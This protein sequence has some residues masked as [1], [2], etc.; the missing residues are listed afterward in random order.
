[1]LEPLG[2][3]LARAPLLPVDAYPTGASHDRV[4]ESLLPTEPLVRA[5]L[6]V[7]TT[8]LYSAL[9]RP[10]QSAAESDR[11]R[12]KLLRYLIRMTTR[13]TPYG[14]FAGVALI[15]WG[16]TTDIFVAHRHLRTRA[17]PDMEWLFG[18]VMEL[19]RDPIVRRELAFFANPLALSRGA[20]ILLSDRA[21][22][23]A[24]EPGVSVRSTAPVRRVLARARV[25]ASY[26][27]LADELLS[28]GATP[29]KSERLIEELWQQSML[30]S[31]L[32]PPLTTPHPARYVCDRLSRVAGA[33]RVHEDLTSLLQA[34]ERWDCLP[35]QDQAG[36]WAA[37][38]EQATRLHPLAT[39]HHAVQVDTAI[40]LA[41]SHV[42]VQVAKEAA[43][44]AELLMRMSPYP[45]GLPYLH[46][47]RRRFEARYGLD[48]E[49]P[50]LELLDPELGLGAPDDSDRDP[51]QHIPKTLRRRT[52]RDVA[53][54][55][56]RE[57]RLII[58]LD[59]QLLSRLQTWIPA[60]TSTPRSIEICVLVAAQSAAAIDAGEFTVIVGPH[61]GAEAAGR[62]LG[63][64]A[65]L[66]G[67]EGCTALR[68]TVPNDDGQRSPLRAELVYLPQ[69]WRA[70]NVAVRPAVVDREIVCGTTPG[71]P[72]E[73]VIP[74]DELV[75]GVCNGRFYVRWPAAARDIAVSVTHMLN[76]RYAPPAIRFLQDV[77]HDGRVVFSHFSWGPATEFPVLPR[78]QRGRVVLAPAQWRLEE[79]TLDS[80]SSDF[81][82]ALR[83]W[84][85]RWSVPRHVYLAEKDHRLLLDLEAPAHC[86]VLREE[87]SRR[88][89]GHASVLQEALPGLA[90]AWLPGPEG[91]H[92][93]EFVVPL[94]ARRGMHTEPVAVQR[95]AV[96]V[97]PAVRL[98]PPGSDWLFLKLYCPPGWQEELVV[99][100][101]AVF[102]GFAESASLADAWFFVRYH[103][104]DAH[105]RVRF[106]GKPEILLTRLQPQACAWA[107]SLV[108]DESCIGFSLETYER[109][110]ERYGGEAGIELAEAL[111]AADSRSAVDLLHRSR[112]HPTL[113]RV[114]LAVLSVDMLL[115]GLAI[116]ADHRLAYYRA[117]TS[118][119]R[120][121]G[122]EY[123]RRRAVLRRLLAHGPAAEP[124]GAA[125]AAILN[126]RRRALQPIAARLDALARDGQLE[127][128]KAALCHSYVHMHC[129]RLIGAGPPTE[130]R[131]LQLARRT[132]ESLSWAYP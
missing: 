88:P 17:R 77:E 73:Q 104:P 120:D 99:E 76:Q 109:E 39:A 122:Q 98:R 105:L 10:R 7:G 24:E 52:L 64:F 28:M 67:P 117:W 15:K 47:Y 2:W 82:I 110:V 127:Q 114:S 21:T 26:A 74:L 107:A 32:R 132:R 37:L 126:A 115:E 62:A 68:E 103:D 85:D 8:D 97:T 96:A 83:A 46:T 91:R 108:A 34:L 121:D 54:G 4:S 51:P 29:A 1:L 102:A 14:L 95:T 116:D 66:L 125:L 87:L 84:R 49:V 63:R 20:Q 90:D 38:T 123:R 36:E 106:H 5:A 124:G 55:A 56:L 42:H 118:L 31:D 6:A 22:G 80:A 40:E 45:S 79:G 94:V 58:E 41:G 72:S 78:V 60:P 89:A 33:R 50:L 93:V 11:L 30:L 43:R 23:S 101:L 3:A 71:C 44:A 27:E 12:G 81:P 75:V 69:R 13:P 61:L 131:I 86:D 92:V 65:E 112:C 111:F 130:N 19:E 48:R 53:L 113:D 70:A 59:D 35:L 9:Q 57:R 119:A 100:E 25:P 18:L 128:N 129:N 16:S